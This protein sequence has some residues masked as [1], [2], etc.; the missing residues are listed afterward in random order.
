MVQNG[1]FERFLRIVVPSVIQ[2]KRTQKWYKK[3]K[4]ISLAEKSDTPLA[5]KRVTHPTHPTL[6]SPP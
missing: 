5:K 2:S 3:Q 1:L 6:S 4:K